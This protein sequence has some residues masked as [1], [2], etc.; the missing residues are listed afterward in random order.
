MVASV[1]LDIEALLETE[2]VDDKGPNGM[3]SSKSV[4][5]KLFQTQM[6]PEKFLSICW[7]SS[8]FSGPVSERSPCA[9]GQIGS[10]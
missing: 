8:E 7:I 9:T 3:L 2:E 6:F 10:T 4:S 1:K 5:T